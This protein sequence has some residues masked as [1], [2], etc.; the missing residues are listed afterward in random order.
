M[1]VDSDFNMDNHRIPDLVICPLCHM[2]FES[3]ALLRKHKRDYCLGHQHDSNWGVKSEQ[4]VLKFSFIKKVP[5][6]ATNFLRSILSLIAAS[7]YSI[8]GINNFEVEY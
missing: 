7:N 3:T 4:Q 2:T 6:F 5:Q 1:D 8:I